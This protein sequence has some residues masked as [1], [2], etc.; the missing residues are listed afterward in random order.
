MAT[1]SWKNLE[2]LYVVLE[3]YWNSWNILEVFIFDQE[4]CFWDIQFAM[5]CLLELD[6]SK[7]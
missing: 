4:S 1:E 3:N 7:I 6:Q 2:N 5:K